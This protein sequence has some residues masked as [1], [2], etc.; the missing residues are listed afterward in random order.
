MRSMM[1]TS[2]TPMKE[3]KNSIAYKGVSL[4]LNY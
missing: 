1:E 3:V 4:I 2:L